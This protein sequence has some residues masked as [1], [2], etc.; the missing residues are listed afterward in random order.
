M[1]QAVNWQVDS[2]P[3]KLFCRGGTVWSSVKRRTE[4]QQNTLHV[5][6]QKLLFCREADE[7][8]LIM[9]W[10]LSLHNGGPLFP[11]N[12]MLNLV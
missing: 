3:G 6:N 8:F 7:K 2:P 10:V 12:L 11:E 5:M 4:G 9:T 1:C